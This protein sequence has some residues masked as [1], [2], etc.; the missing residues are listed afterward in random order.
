MKAFFIVYDTLAG[1]IKY[2]FLSPSLTSD[3]LSMSKPSEPIS[4]PGHVL[5][6][7]AN[8]KLLLILLACWFFVSFGL[9]ILLVDWLD[10]FHFMGFPF[11]FW[12]AQQGSIIAFLNARCW[13]WM[14]SCN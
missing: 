5:Y 11:G 14:V 4:D 9:S 1:E 6:W 7:K 12:M 2:Q 13:S 3:P 10:Q 8:I